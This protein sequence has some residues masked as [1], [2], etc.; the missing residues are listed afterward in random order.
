M[1]AIA[2][3][4]SPFFITVAV[5]IWLPFVPASILGFA[6]MALLILSFLAGACIHGFLLN[7]W[8]WQYGHL[9]LG[10]VSATAESFG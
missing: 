4:F 9:A 2:V 10:T 7:L 8:N 5:M 3:F 6:A 1:V